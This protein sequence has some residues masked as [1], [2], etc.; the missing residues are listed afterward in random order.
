MPHRR[1][2]WH[3]RI[4]AV[5]REYWAARIAVDRLTADVARDPG[6]LG[7]GPERRDLIAANDNI[8]GTYLIRMFAEFESGIRSFWIADRRRTRPQAEVLL[9]RVG[10]SRGIPGDVIIDVH[11][12]R[13]YRNSLLHDREDEVEVVTVSQARRCF[14]TYL[15]RLPN[16]WRD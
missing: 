16:Q 8:E 4:K 9:D 6:V 12:A 1:S 2:D 15:A 3:E 5:E 14:Q 7:I 13:I 10:T 11:A